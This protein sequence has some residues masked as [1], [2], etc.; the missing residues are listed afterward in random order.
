M[1]TKT[2]VYAAGRKSEMSATVEKSSI[3]FWILNVFVVA[4]LFWAPFQRGLFNGGNYEFERPIYSSLVWTAI[5]LFLS[6]LLSFF[7]YR[8]RDQ[9]DVLTALVLFMPLSYTVSLTTAA[10]SLLA[11]NM[12]LIQLL[13]ATFFILGV[14]LTKNKLGTSIV[15]GSILASGY[16]VVLF[17]L[18]Y[19]LGNKEFIDAI[20]GWF[21][22]M[23]PATNDYRDAVMTDSNGLR[24]TAVFQYANSYAAFLIAFMLAALFYIV[25]A[26]K[27]HTALPHALMVVP[28][29]VSFWLTL[30]RG[31][32]VIVPAV[33]LVMLFFMSIKRQ[34]ISILNL[35]LGF[36]ASLL[37]LSKVTEVG[38]QLQKQPSGALSWEGWSAL[39]IASIVFAAFAIAIQLFLEPLLERSTGR[40]NARKSAPFILPVIAVVAA[41]LG[42]VLLLGDTP[43]RNMLPENIKFRLA[44]I[45]FEQNS[46]LERVTFYN[47]AMKL[48]KDYPIIG[49]G[50]GGWAAL[51]EKYQNNPYTSRQAHNFLLQYLV[52]TGLLGLLS[53][54]GF[55][56]A[57]FWFYIRSF[58][59]STAEQR[60]Q[61]FLFFIVAVALLAHSLIDFDM[62]Y[63]YLGALVFL[64][65]GGILGGTDSQP[66]RIRTDSL[67]LH[68]AFPSLLLLLSVVMFIFSARLLGAD[69]DYRQ[70]LEIIKTNKNYND[71]V[72]PLDSAINQHPNHPDYVLTGQL[73]KIGL[74]VQVYNQTK[75]EKFM[76]EAQTLLDNLAKAE[77]HNRSVVLQ[78]INF[79][80][81]QN[82][83]PEALDLMT[84]ELPNFPWYIDMYENQMAMSVDLA[85][86]SRAQNNLQA[87]DK[88]LS[89]AL[90]SYSTVLKQI[91]HL[92]TLPKG[93]LQG[94]PFDVTPTIAMLIGQVHYA[95][96]DFAAAA[97][98]MKPYVTDNMDDEVNRTLVRWFV[99]SLQ[100]QGQ[101]D[102]SLYDKLIAK[103]PNEKNVI[104]SILV[105]NTQIK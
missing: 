36:G 15:V 33:F 89:L 102:Q 42:A 27:W 17:G 7:I 82:K 10:S 91:E 67:V 26:R 69:S 78:R 12:V 3:I 37:I 23:D 49:A 64:S 75:D 21:A 59:R 29:I 80:Q 84:K 38:T 72:R 74:L 94:R 105:S 79:L 28:I 14:F 47:D 13:Y 98:L 22:Y 65:L 11:A 90:D 56:A 20:V 6:A 97:A 31:A 19:W 2:N 55:V 52:E 50:G 100:K 44:N 81:M 25:K 63:V 9:K 68:K 5:I 77:P 96:G 1:S 88:Y 16:I 86:Q 93:Q 71:I 24:L 87:A 95:R 48:F 104:A 53:F 32:L 35:V 103:D 39:L 60:D 51:Y 30:S 40:F 83:L 92:K 41:A 54:V 99:A 8:I 46:V 61:Y 18:L 76:T 34:I 57:I 45:N 66:I 58:I 62:S 4:F 73:S 43:V 101:N 85:N 70:S